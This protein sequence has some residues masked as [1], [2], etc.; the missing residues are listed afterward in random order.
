LA[1]AAAAYIVETVGLLEGVQSGRITA[2]LRTLVPVFEANPT[3]PGVPEALVALCS[4]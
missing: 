2:R 1:L 3:V 4:A